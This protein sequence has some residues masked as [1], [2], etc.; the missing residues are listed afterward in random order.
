M[1]RREIWLDKSARPASV[2][3]RVFRGGGRARLGWGR[4][5]RPGCWESCRGW[6]AVR[7]PRARLKSGPRRAAAA[8]A[9]AQDDGDR[10]L[11][12]FRHARIQ[13]HDREQRFRI[14]EK[15]PRRAA[16]TCDLRSHAARIRC[17]RGAHS[18]T[19]RW[20]PHL[21]PPHTLT[22]PQD[23]RRILDAGADIAD[24]R[25]QQIYTHPSGVIGGTPATASAATPAPRPAQTPPPTPGSPP[26]TTPRPLPPRPP[27]PPTAAQRRPQPPAESGP[28]GLGSVGRTTPG[29]AGGHPAA[30]KRRRRRSPPP[31]RRCR[32]RRRRRQWGPAGRRPRPAQATWHDRPRRA[33]RRRR[34]AAMGRG[35]AAASRGGRRRGRGRCGRRSGSR[36]RG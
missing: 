12:T 22:Q 11:H 7:A 29:S 27:R 14:K 17:G 30:W 31:P 32:R 8:H 34:P 24:R 4:P 36:G 16:T 26:P 3:C 18:P 25:L 5:G 33:Q 35:R 28:L 13:T 20:K 19:A 9:V 1:T 23:R 10:S 2:P 21:A 15:A 6:S